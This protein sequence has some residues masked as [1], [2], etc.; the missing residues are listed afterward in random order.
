[1]SDRCADHIGCVK[2]VVAA[3]RRD[4]QDIPLRIT[5]LRVTGRV[6]PKDLAEDLERLETTVTD[7]VRRL[8]GIVYALL[9]AVEATTG[10]RAS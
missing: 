4:M 8:S 5:P 7:D 10:E 9:G 6:R 1:V 3:A 2:C